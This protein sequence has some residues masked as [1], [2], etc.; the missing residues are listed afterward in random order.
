[1]IALR[2]HEKEDH[3]S[4][5]PLRLVLV[6]DGAVTTYKQHSIVQEPWTHSSWLHLGQGMFEC[7]YMESEC[8][9]FRRMKGHAQELDQHQGL[10][11]L[12]LLLAEG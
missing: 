1:M 8:A 6:K 3:S 11:S 4:L 2:T 9:K 7:G 5:L 10:S 12:A